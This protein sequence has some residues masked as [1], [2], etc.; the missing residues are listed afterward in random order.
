MG[1]SWG[2]LGGLRKAWLAKE[3][4][5]EAYGALLDGSW[6]ALGAEKST[7]ERLLAAPREMPR[8]VSAILGAKRLPKGGPRGSKI[9]A[10]RRLELKTRFL[11]KPLFFLWISLIFEIPGS[12]FGGQNRWKLASDCSLAAES[13]LKASRMALGALLIDS[14]AEKK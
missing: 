3:G 5:P 7:L 12:S 4:L 8:Q 14:R 9:E 11:Q 10:K 2:S 6:G 13:L 1:A